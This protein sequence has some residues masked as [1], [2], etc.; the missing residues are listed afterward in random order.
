[1]KSKNISCC[2]E[3]QVGE[4]VNASVAVF[5]LMFCILFRIKSSILEVISLVF[6][7]ITS[8][9]ASAIGTSI[10]NRQAFVKGCLYCVLKVAEDASTV[11]I[12]IQ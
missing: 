5:V 3:N 9:C 8:V 10:V 11:P 6:D 1:M 12:F 7:F 4:R 2:Y